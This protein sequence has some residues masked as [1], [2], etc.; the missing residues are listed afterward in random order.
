MVA[1]DTRHRFLNAALGDKTL[2]DPLDNLGQHRIN[3]SNL[4]YHYIGNR[5]I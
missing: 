3:L 2:L 5:R 1:A 4:S